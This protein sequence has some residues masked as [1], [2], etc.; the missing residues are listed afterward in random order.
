VWLGWIAAG[1]VGGG[2][3]IPF[4][5]GSLL[6]F[7]V[8]FGLFFSVPQW[9]VLRPW[10][11]DPDSWILFT[12]LGGMAAW[13]VGGTLTILF[14]LTLPILPWLAGLR[15]AWLEN[16][17][18]LLLVVAPAGAVLG[19]AQ[20]I[21]F[22]VRDGSS[23]VDFDFR[24]IAARTWVGASAAGWVLFWWVA[25][26]Q[27][28]VPDLLVSVPSVRSNAVGGA[29]AGLAHGAVTGVALIRLMHDLRTR[30]DDQ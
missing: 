17:I 5:P 24:S 18:W 9:L 27:P 29:L 30:A 20:V 1:A 10:L 26:A 25:L 4:A 12:V 11:P 8:P 28:G 7:A 3:T 23:K 6:F 13:L 19:L 21:A 14:G 15:P 2:L 22:A 16:A